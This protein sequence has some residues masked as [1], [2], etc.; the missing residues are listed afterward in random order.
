MKK[1]LNAF[2]ILFIVSQMTLAA[3]TSTAGQSEQIAK[4]EANIEKLIVADQN[5]NAALQ[6]YVAAAKANPQEVYYR[7]QYAILQRV[8]KMQSLLE[9]ELNL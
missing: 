4:F 7:Q 8:I 5:M 9:T 2:W 6:E 1:Y 3:E